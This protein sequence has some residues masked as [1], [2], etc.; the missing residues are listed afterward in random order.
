[1][2]KIYQPAR[3]RRKQTIVLP[4]PDDIAIGEMQARGGGA[5]H[6]TVLLP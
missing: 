5:W 1:M 3:D 6:S 2:F 4:V